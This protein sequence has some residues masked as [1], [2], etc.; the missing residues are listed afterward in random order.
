ML[1][2]NFTF[3]N[4]DE[5]FACFKLL[6]IICR[7]V[8]PTKDMAMYYLAWLE[9]IVMPGIYRLKEDAPKYA[10]MIDWVLAIMLFF[11][12]YYEKISIAKIGQ[13]EMPPPNAIEE[14]LGE[15]FNPLQIKVDLYINNYKEPV[16]SLT[17]D[18][19]T[20]VYQFM[21]FVKEQ[22]IFVKTF[23]N[24]DFLWIYKCDYWSQSEDIAMKSYEML[25]HLV[26]ESENQYFKDEKENMI[27]Y[28]KNRVFPLY[29]PLPI[30]EEDV[31]LDTMWNQVAREFTLRNH[32]QSYL[33]LETMNEL[34]CLMFAIK[35]RREN[36]GEVILVETG[37]IIEKY[38]EYLPDYCEKYKSVASWAFSMKT[39]I[40]RNLD[41]FLKSNIH[42]LK[43]Q[44]ISKVIDSF[45]FCS[46]T[47]KY[48]IVDSTEFEIPELQ[49]I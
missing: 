2:R 1:N 40:D 35:K 22:E 49:S 26:I 12:G 39:Q 5:I 18:I 36:K 32:Y 44:F 28:V 7:Y 34:A 17:V 6:Y 48:K 11:W 16:V 4:V 23:D 14:I 33:D 29:Y 13:P 24:V 31:V 37:D 20:R 10:K 8:I 25:S 9:V 27:F 47:F 45:A 15:E 21:E 19:F 41:F 42:E 3:D 30:F 38:E 43:T 46:N